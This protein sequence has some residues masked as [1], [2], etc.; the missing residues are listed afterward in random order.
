MRGG[1][2]VRVSKRPW[3]GSWPDVIESS[4]NVINDKKRGT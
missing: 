4:L 3:S 2:T 1:H